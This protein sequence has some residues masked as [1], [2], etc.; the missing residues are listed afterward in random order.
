MTQ[1]DNQTFQFFTKSQAV[2][3]KTVL[4]RLIPDNDK[5][6]AAGD[7]GI[8]Q[9]LDEV[10]SSQT[11]A[12]QDI[13]DMHKL[14]EAGMLLIDRSSEE[15]FDESFIN[16]NREK[17]I[18]VLVQVEKNEPVFFSTLVHHTY[19]GY[20]TNQLILEI[21]EAPINPPQPDGHYLEPGDLS[22]L[23]SVQARGQAYRNAPE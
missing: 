13:S 11:L 8:L 17:Q 4:N 20:Y 18:N 21:C 19:N 6:P 14:F 9:H 3:M 7:I 10:L 23:S 12:S 15:L 16:L 22:S 1:E 2:L 5:Y